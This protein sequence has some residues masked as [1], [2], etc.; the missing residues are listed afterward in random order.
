MLKGSAYWTYDPEARAWYFGLNERAPMPYRQRIFVEAILDLDS[1]GRL[2]G[3]E[4]I[5]QKVDGSPIKPPRSV[6]E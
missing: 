2:A 5:A 1:D 4:I 6:S 3:V